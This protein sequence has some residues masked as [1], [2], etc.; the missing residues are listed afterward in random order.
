MFTEFLLTALAIF[1]FAVFAIRP[2]LITIGAL[3]SEISE[4]EDT[5]QKLE[6]KINNL[7]LAQENFTRETARLNL[8]ST[9][10]PIEPEIASYVKQIESIAATHSVEVYGF[11]TGAAPI[12]ITPDQS[13]SE[14]QVHVTITFTGT[15]ANLVATLK[16]LENLRRPIQLSS[17]GLSV[18]ESTGSTII[19]LTATGE[20]PFFPIV[21]TI[22]TN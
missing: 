11:T 3:T 4:K 13:D 9:A 8:L 14:L 2:T 17:G 21:N 18:D 12:A 6:T 22:P 19:Y 16:D 20:I 1:V 10:V 7:I 15:Y 5:V